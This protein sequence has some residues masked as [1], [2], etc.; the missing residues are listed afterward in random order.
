MSEFLEHLNFQ[1]FFSQISMS[2]YL[3]PKDS[4]ATTVVAIIMITN[5][6][7]SYY[8]LRD[9]SDNTD[10]NSSAW[11]QIFFSLNLFSIE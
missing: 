9:G 7:N 2:F 8:F 10:D 4:P 1:Q 6:N 3:Y 11:W 5:N